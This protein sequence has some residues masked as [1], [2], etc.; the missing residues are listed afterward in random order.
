MKNKFAIGAIGL[1]SFVVLII[2]ISAKYS[3]VSQVL[4]AKTAIIASTPVIDS[5]SPLPS[6]IPTPSPTS[7]P[8]TAPQIYCTNGTY[9]NS[10]GNTVCRPESPPPNNMIPYG[11]T[12][13]CRDG[14]YSFSQHR[15]GT[16]SHHGGVAQWY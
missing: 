9:I 6:I 10:F 8:S 16:C 15:Q 2:G 1:V 11:A 3:H 14:S 4:S 5:P 12:A 7:Y 13:Q